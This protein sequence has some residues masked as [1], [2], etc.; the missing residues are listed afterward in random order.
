MSKPIAGTFTGGC[1]CG[2]IRYRATERRDD[3]HICHCRM[4]QKA[5]GGY[6]AALV[7]I[8]DEALTWT[9]GV[10]SVFLSSDTTER[11]FCSNCGTPL[12]CRFIGDDYTDINIATLDDP[13]AVAPSRQIGNESRVGYLDTLHTLPGRETTT[14]ASDPDLANTIASS[15]HQHPDEETMDWK[16]RPRER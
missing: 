3:A 7:G 14:E 12:F 1:Q 8:P 6:F 4:C 5:V 16:P 9:R 15:N 13:D 2:S 10:P 11:G